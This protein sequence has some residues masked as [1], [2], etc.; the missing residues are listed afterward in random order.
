MAVCLANFCNMQHASFSKLAP[1]FSWHVNIYDHVL[2]SKLATPTS[3]LKPIKCCDLVV[4]WANS[5][6]HLALV[7]DTKNWWRPGEQE[8][9][10]RPYSMPKYAFPGILKP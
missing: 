8:A 3:E 4:F 7:T 9:Q 10:F 2:N 5:G 1:F 6:L